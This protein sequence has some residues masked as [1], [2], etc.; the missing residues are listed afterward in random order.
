MWCGI[1]DDFILG[2]FMLPPRL[3]GMGYLDFLVNEL[4]TVSENVPL[5]TRREM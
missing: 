1:A 2:P 4:P 5:A 3:T